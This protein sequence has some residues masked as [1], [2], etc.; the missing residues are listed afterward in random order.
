MLRMLS[1]ITGS[2]THHCNPLLPCRL[3]AAEPEDVTDAALLVFS[4]ASK[5]RTE[6]G[7]RR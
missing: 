7:T 4:K 2:G 5:R 1:P 6:T 3:A